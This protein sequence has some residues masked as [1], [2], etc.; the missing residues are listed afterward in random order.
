MAILP[1]YHSI[2]IN[3][4]FVIVFL[5]KK[6]FVSILSAT[7]AAV[8][9]SA[10]SNTIKPVFASSDTSQQCKDAAQKISNKA[11]AHQSNDVCGIE[12]S[13]DSPTLTLDGKK[14][15]DQVPMEFLYQP[16]SASSGSRVLMLTEFTLLQSEVDKVQQSLLDH[17]WTVTAVHNHQFFESPRLIYLHAQKQDNLVNILNEIRNALQQTT[18]GCT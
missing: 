13:R 7:L 18:C 3:G 4:M 17:H 14:I 11:E 5:M 1:V 16:A 12:L 15:N 10:T 9:F 2:A 6:L 8:L